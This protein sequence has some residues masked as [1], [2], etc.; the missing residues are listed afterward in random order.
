MK[1][2]FICKDQLLSF[3]FTQNLFSHNLAVYFLYVFPLW[4][5]KQCHLVKI[6]P[7]I[8][9]RSLF[10]QNVV[11][12][13]WAAE[14]GKGSHKKMG[15]SAKHLMLTYKKSPQTPLKV[16]PVTVFKGFLW[17]THYGGK[18]TNILMGFQP[19]AAITWDLLSSI[20]LKQ[21]QKHLI[22]WGSLSV[23][24]FLIT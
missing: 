11:R 19:G 20:I 22:A 16:I 3:C 23:S 15:L 4:D 12:C 2:H 1:S 17:H 18:E 7:L 13:Y 5:Q 14:C 8:L 24:S 21:N 6:C 9:S 10:M